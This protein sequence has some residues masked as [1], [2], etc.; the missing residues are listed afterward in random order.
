MSVE[1]ATLEKYTEDLKAVTV[2]GSENITKAIELL[3]QVR[4]VA[5]TEDALRRTGLNTVL[6]TLRKHTDASLVKE[7]KETVAVFKA[8]LGIGERRKATE[9]T[10]NADNGTGNPASSPTSAGSEAS[11]SPLPSGDKSSQDQEQTGKRV[12]V[13]ASLSLD[14]TDPAAATTAGTTPTTAGK[15]T[16][17][18]ASAEASDCRTPG[19]HRFLTG[20]D[21]NDKQRTEY[22]LGFDGDA[23]RTKMQTIIHDAL[24]NEFP[25]SLRVEIAV[26]IEEAIFRVHGQ[27]NGGASSSDYRN[28]IR[29]LV[30]N[31]RD[32]DNM[33]IN[34]RLLTGEVSPDDVA[35][36]KEADMASDALKRL[37][38]ETERNAID[39]RR[40]DWDK[41]HGAGATDEFKCHKCKKR[42]CTYF[43]KQT[44]SSDEPMTTFITCLECGYRWREY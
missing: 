8:A 31:L 30:A 6:N 40:S 13:D 10:L 29:A 5:V 12:K 36:M 11:G 22:K 34:R 14:T 2:P 20:W 41:E 27:P 4:K 33:D 1:T 44:R 35:T 15:D 37:R 23:V 19:G 32:P 25:A 26:Q 21:D 42:R 3:V 24:G 16:M 43:Q 18:S 7:V 17:A 28:Q 9:A 38:Q 39:A